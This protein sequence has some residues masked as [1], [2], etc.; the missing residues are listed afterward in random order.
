MATVRVTFQCGCGFTTARVE[1]AEEHSDTNSHI[2]E[3][4]G[5]IKPE[6]KKPTDKYRR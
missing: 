4:R 3:A 1:E 6:T 5:L 2:M